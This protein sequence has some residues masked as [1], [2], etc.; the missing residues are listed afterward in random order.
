MSSWYKEKAPENDIV[1]SSR[2]RLA[3]NLEKLPF[4]AKMN[5]EQ[6]KQLNDAVKDAVTGSVDPLASSLT[7][8]QMD[9][10]PQ[11]EIDAMV[12]RHIISPEFAQ[13]SEGR[14]LL[15][16][17]DE[18]V[19]VMVGE[20]DHIRIQVLRGGLQPD[21]AYE[22]AKQ[23]DALLCAKLHFAFDSRLGYLTGCPTNLGTGLRASVMLHLPVLESNNG[24]AEL[25]NSV[26]KI[27]FTVRGMYGEGSKTYASMY[28][29]SNQITLG[30]TEQ[31]AI[32]NLKI[33]TMQI[34][35]K[36]RTARENLNCIRLE[37][38]CCRALGVLQNCRLCSSEEMMRL[39][40]SCQLG[41]SVGILDAD[42]DPISLLIEG[43]PHML[44]KQYGTADAEE[45]DRY[46]ADF[47]RK[48]LSKEE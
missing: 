4:P 5:A 17:H 34:V 22:T 12:E 47:L 46:R 42:I 23:L 32:E 14:A 1:I 19:S 29:I 27:G 7:F 45:R 16:S 2:I 26:A 8:I 21:K 24:I 43:Q 13:N 9:D 11:N 10:V 3:R 39:L 18:T 15:L 30:I 28:Q 38:L 31:N 33:I 20:E 25:T 44:M 40:S 37:D 41:K 48:S 6:R 35:E 36:E